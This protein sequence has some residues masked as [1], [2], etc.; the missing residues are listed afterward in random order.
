MRRRGQRVERAERLV[1]EDQFGIA[2]QR[3]SQRDALLP[4]PDS[5]LGHYCASRE[6]DLA[7]RRLGAAPESGS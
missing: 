7:R 3:A 2:H 4:P 5:V 6:P 1:G